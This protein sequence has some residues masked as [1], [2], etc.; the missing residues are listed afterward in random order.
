MIVD[1]TNSRSSAVGYDV[2]GVAEILCRTK[3]HP[4]NLVPFFQVGSL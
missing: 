2:I 1:V 4:L 3:A